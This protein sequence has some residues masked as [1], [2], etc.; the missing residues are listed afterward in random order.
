MIA[1][2]FIEIEPVDFFAP[3]E[4]SETQTCTVSLQI[5]GRAAPTG[6]IHWVM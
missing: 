1:V 2:G 6:W 3:I 4:V 5:A